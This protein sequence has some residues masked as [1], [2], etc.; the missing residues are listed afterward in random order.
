[1]LQLGAEVAAEPEGLIRIRE[2]EAE[3][4]EL[5]ASKQD[6]DRRELS[7]IQARTQ[8]REREVQLADKRLEEARQTLLRT[9]QQ[10]RENEEMLTK[11]R[12]ETDKRRERTQSI[13]REIEEQRE[14]ERRTG[15]EEAVRSGRP[16]QAAGPVAAS[17]LSTEYWITE[18]DDVRNAL[19]DVEGEGPAMVRIV[20]DIQRLLVQ[21]ET[22]TA[23]EIQRVWELLQ[24]MVRDIGQTGDKEV[25]TLT[26]RF[27]DAGN[28]L[29]EM[30]AQNVPT[31][32]K[33]VIKKKTYAAPLA[34][35]SPASS[36]SSMYPHPDLATPRGPTSRTGPV[37]RQDIAAVEAE[38]EGVR[39]CSDVGEEERAGAEEYTTEP[40]LASPTIKYS[41]TA[42]VAGPPLATRTAG[43]PVL[44]G[45]APP[46]LATVTDQRRIF[47]DNRFDGNTLTDASTHQETEAWLR[48]ARIYI[49][50]HPE[51]PQSEVATKLGK[52]IDPKSIRFEAARSELDPQ[53]LCAVIERDKQRALPVDMELKA[54]A[55]FRFD[56]TSNLSLEVMR[57]QNHAHRAFPRSEHHLQDGLVWFEKAL[58]ALALSNQ[59]VNAVYQQYVA[60]TPSIEDR[61]MEAWRNKLEKIGAD[62]MQSSLRD[63]AVHAIAYGTGEQQRSLQAASPESERPKKRELEGAGSP[64]ATKRYERSPDQPVQRGQEAEEGEGEYVQGEYPAPAFRPAYGRGGYR[65]RYSASGGYRDVGG[66][67]RRGSRPFTRPV[68]FVCNGTEPPAN[69]SHNMCPRNQCFNC[70]EWGHTTVKCNRQQV[71]CTYPMR[72]GGP[73]GERGHAT[74]RHEEWAKWQRE[75][76]GRP[77][78]V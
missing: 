78:V 43:K 46:A 66:R 71:T 27:A 77:D 57:F 7:Q 33:V 38:E 47:L 39:M 32:R 25:D 51:L 2:A 40:P 28:V 60:S 62:K 72:S 18:L 15:E 67:G 12:E 69:H 70:Q 5:G 8:E 13:R 23:S 61:T 64:P 56:P 17:Y 19:R 31:K 14:R 48:I 35:H 63:A 30:A 59:G 10:Q 42:T 16:S 26:K 24:E 58:A 53:R 76:K 44:T 29:R 6:R 45:Q 54:L 11:I 68:C 75:I 41:S 20:E 52:C 36:S 9:E 55:D 50:N 65:G 74:S 4:I 34:T 37:R 49:R 21:P 22:R 1:M 73:C 3:M